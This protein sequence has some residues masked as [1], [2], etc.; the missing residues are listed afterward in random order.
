L[1]SR[2]KGGRDWKGAFLREKGEKK[3]KKSDFQSEWKK[4]GPIAEGETRKKNSV[5]F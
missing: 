1:S 2:K 5:V 4:K 3:K